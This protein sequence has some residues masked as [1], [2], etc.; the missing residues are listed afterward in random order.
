MVVGVT[1]SKTKV[2]RAGDIDSLDEV[3]IDIVAKVVDLS[4]TLEEMDDTMDEDIKDLL[5]PS[6][7]GSPRDSDTLYEDIEE[8]IDVVC[9]RPVVVKESPN[10]L[11]SSV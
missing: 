4:D 3:D 6:I 8:E 5:V 10:E 2:V 7:V 11:L 1:D 9:T